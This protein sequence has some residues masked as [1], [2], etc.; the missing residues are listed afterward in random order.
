MSVLLVEPDADLLDLLTFML[1]REGHD[2]IC[3]KDEATALVRYREQ[4]P[5]LVLAATELAD[6]SGWSLCHAIRRDG[7]TPVILIGKVQGEDETVRALEG[8][9]DAYLAKPLSPRVLLAT[10]RSTLRRASAMPE[11][12]VALKTVKAGDLTIDSQWR[13]VQRGDERIALTLIELKI[14]YELAIH[15]GQVL[16]HQML[17]DRV[18]GYDALE[19]GT[20]GALLKGHIRNLRRKLG[21]SAEQPS[22]IETVAG[23]GYCF[24]ASDAADRSSTPAA[25]RRDALARE[26]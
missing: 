25:E 9:A 12:R 22:Y 24:R 20:D 15:Q 13:Q 21:D 23:V 19:A 26:A 11:A 3:A 7:G 6:G 16:T 14:L 1:R 10:V 8:G 4:R 17:V 2:V 5:I 18:W